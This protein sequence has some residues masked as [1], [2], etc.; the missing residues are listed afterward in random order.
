MQSNILQNLIIGMVVEEMEDHQDL[1]VVLMTQVVAVVVTQ[2][3]VSL[4]NQM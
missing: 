4:G 2:E 3:E 1:E